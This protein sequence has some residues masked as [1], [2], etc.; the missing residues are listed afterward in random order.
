[1]LATRLDTVL[2]LLKTAPAPV[3]K[4]GAKPAAGTSVACEGFEASNL[5]TT[6]KSKVDSLSASE[7]ETFKKVNAAFQ[8]DV[9]V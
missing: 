6:I 7:K 4:G 3:Q 1:M 2:A 8:F 5:F 9:K